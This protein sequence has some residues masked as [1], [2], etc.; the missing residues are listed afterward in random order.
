MEDPGRLPDLVIGGQLHLPNHQRAGKVRGGHVVG[1]RH[2]SKGLPVRLDVVTVQSCGPKA[3]DQPDS[4]RP[5]AL[6]SSAVVNM[7]VVKEN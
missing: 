5:G 3:G 7:T 4:S 1:D 2:P 6:E